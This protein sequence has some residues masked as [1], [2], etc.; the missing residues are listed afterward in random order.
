MPSSLQLSR[1]P[2]VKETAFFFWGVRLPTILAV[3]ETACR[4][5]EGHWTEIIVRCD[6]NRLHVLLLNVVLT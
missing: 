6:L 5:F 1:Q 2:D 3:S 4:N